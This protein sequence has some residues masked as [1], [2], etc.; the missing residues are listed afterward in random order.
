MT[1]LP[2]R[3]DTTVAISRWVGR[4]PEVAY[5]LHPDLRII[6][7]AARG[8]STGRLVDRESI[9]Y[10]RIEEIL[11]EFGREWYDMVI[12]E[13]KTFD[14]GAAIRA[15]V[16]AIGATEIRQAV[17]EIVEQDQGLLDRLAET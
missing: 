14:F 12:R 9:D 13:G 3:A 16:E 15:L 7:D 8:W 6:L 4:E 2:S 10:G 11:D 5:D 1:D 17:K